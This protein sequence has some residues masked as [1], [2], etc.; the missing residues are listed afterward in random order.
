MHA[1][2][3]R[4]AHHRPDR[5]WEVGHTLYCWQQ[6]V[7]PHEGSDI[8][9]SSVPNENRTDPTIG[10]T[11]GHQIATA[12]VEWVSALE[13]SRSLSF[14]SLLSHPRQRTNQRGHVH[15][16]LGYLKP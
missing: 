11:R 2:A 10:I 13:G 3:H 7:I 15:V 1:S 9:V 8:S 16:N 5:H 14:T 12:F 4:T 6:Q